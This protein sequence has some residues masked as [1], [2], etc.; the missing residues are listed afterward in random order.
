[1]ARI[2]HVTV[3]HFV[4]AFMMYARGILA[5]TGPLPGGLR[6]GCADTGHHHHHHHHHLRYRSEDKES[7]IVSY[8]VV[9]SLGHLAT[10]LDQPTHALSTSIARSK[11]IRW[12]GVYPRPSIAKTSPP[13]NFWTPHTHIDSWTATPDGRV[14]ATCLG[15]SYLVC[16]ASK[17]V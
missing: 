5:S 1:M 15:S 12:G 16:D 6:R 9:H 11:P 7:W 14:C 8:R 13:S 2:K 4:S 17:V 10:T 3:L